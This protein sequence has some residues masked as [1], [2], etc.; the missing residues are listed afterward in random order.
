MSTLKKSLVA[1]ALMF[2]LF[3]APAEAAKAAGAFTYY[4]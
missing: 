3:A 1:A 2:S 4:T